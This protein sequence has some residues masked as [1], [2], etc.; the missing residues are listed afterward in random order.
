MKESKSNGSLNQ[1]LNMASS[2]ASRER[3]RSGTRQCDAGLL[4]RSEPRQKTDDA[5]QFVGLAGHE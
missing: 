5:K 3:K 2:S 1:K 4:H